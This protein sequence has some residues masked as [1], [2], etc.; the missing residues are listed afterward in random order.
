MWG[1]AT[2]Y[3]GTEGGARK[4][5]VSRIEDAVISYILRHRGDIA[6]R[7]GRKIVWDGSGAPSPAFRYLLT[8]SWAQRENPGL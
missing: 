7:A 2:T 8:R 6:V 3:I 1:Y 5:P 4:D